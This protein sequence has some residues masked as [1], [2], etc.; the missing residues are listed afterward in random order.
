MNSQHT[1]Y[2]HVFLY[3]VCY[4]AYIF[5]LSS[6]AFNFQYINL[7]IHDRFTGYAEKQVTC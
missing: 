2:Q 4:I 5:M 6:V 1:F 3:L 7:E